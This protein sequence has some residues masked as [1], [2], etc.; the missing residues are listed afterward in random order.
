LIIYSL[1]DEFYLIEKSIESQVQYKD[2]V[3]ETDANIKNVKFRCFISMILHENKQDAFFD[4]IFSEGI[5]S[6]SGTFYDEDSILN[7]RSKNKIRSKMIR[8]LKKIFNNPILRMC[9]DYS[10][11]R[12][13]YDIQDY[14]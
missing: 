14:F 4:F 5:E 1:E 11:K 9:M 13:E 10:T 12:N 3:I 2:L 8:S 6:T 7:F